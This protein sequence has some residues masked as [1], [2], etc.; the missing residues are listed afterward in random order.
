[1]IRRWWQFFRWSRQIGSWRVVHTQAGTVQV[2]WSVPAAGDWYFYL[3][4]QWSDYHEACGAAQLLNAG[5]RPAAAGGGRRRPAQ[6][7]AC[8]ELFP[9]RLST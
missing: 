4:D 8:R 5:R 2:R 3:P 6:F 7:A 1:M 9:G